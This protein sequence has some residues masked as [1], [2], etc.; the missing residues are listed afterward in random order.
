MAV[1]SACACHKVARYLESPMKTN[2][3]G[4]HEQVR[5]QLPD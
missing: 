3:A 2:G 4:R 5:Q 1:R